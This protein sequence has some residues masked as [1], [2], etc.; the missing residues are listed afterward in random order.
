M[1]KL[2][3]LAPVA[4]AAAA[5]LHP[6]LAAP[7]WAGEEAE[8][9]C[10]LA[11]LGEADRNAI[12][13]ISEDRSARRAAMEAVARGV[14]ECA[15]RFGWSAE[16]RSAASHYVGPFIAR[17]RYRRVLAGEGLDLA[18]IERNVH[19]DAPLMA[20][21]FARR[22]SPPEL[23]KHLQRLIA[24]EQAWITRNEVAREKLQ[25]LGGLVSATA[26][27]EAAR[28]RFTRE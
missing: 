14:A 10:P 8:L 27:A 5:L 11:T 4:A 12:A 3:V 28:L 16:E 9:N 15:N 22:P 7:A 21:A 18:R 23:D 24:A 25:A 19:A 2:H 20:A 13:T 26:L 17:E 6:G 1:R